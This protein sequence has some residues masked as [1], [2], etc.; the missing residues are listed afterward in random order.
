MYTHTQRYRQKFTAAIFEYHSF[1]WAPSVT[2]VIFLCILLMSLILWLLQ[3]HAE[4]WELGK[5]C[6]ASRLPKWNQLSR[7]NELHGTRAMNITG[8]M[9]GGRTAASKKEKK[10]FTKEK[11]IKIRAIRRKT[12]MFCLNSVVGFLPG[13][14][15]APVL[16]Q[17]SCMWQ[18]SYRWSRN[19][20]HAVLSA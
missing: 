13:R 6:L 20:R 7:L 9:Q 15:P 2:W 4:L 1:S 8:E 17:A 10:L 19:S 5:T 14:P 12:N 16:I 3:L 18:E 11:K